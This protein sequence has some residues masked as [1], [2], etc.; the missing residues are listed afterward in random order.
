MMVADDLDSILHLGQAMA[1]VEVKA[2][3]LPR[4]EQL[5]L[6]AQLSIVVPG[7]DDR[8]AKSRDPFEELVR[9]HGRRPVVHQIAENDQTARPIFRDQLEQALGDRRHPPHRNQ[10]A[11]CA[12]A[13][14]IAEMQVR[15]GEPA[16]PLMKERETAIEQ[17]FV[18]D[19]RLVG[20][21]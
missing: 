20:T 6:A 10:P 16:F 9:C 12:L 11:R 21:E 19:E 3:G 5:E 8:L 18:G 17:D 15:H 1:M 7:Y 14:F 4:F 13:Q 2:L